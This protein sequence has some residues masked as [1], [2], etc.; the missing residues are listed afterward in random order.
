M[1]QKFAELE[2]LDNSFYDLGDLKKH[3]ALC[4]HFSNLIELSLINVRF[5]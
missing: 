3:L 5:L 2:M 4:K 1:F